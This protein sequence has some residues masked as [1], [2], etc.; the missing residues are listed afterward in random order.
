MRS[1]APK[2]KECFSRTLEFLMQQNILDDQNVK[3]WNETWNV[4][5][6]FFPDLKQ[7]LAN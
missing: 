3:I 1:L 5:S 7:S 4:I 6:S 2:V